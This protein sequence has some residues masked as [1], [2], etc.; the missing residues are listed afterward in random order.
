M[1]KKES[2]ALSLKTQ[3]EQVENESDERQMYLEHGRTLA[4]GSDGLEEFIEIRASSGAL[5]LR[6]KMT[7][8]GPVLALEG[9]KL[10]VKAQSSIEMECT[11]FSVNASESVELASEQ[12]LEVSSKG[13][14]TIQSEGADVRVKGEKIFLN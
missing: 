10:A 7:E 4:V 2:V 3:D 14:L 13:E 1:S 5:E 11:R 6:I 8:E 9:I 12:K